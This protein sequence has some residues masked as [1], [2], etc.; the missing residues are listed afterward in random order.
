LFTLRA[1]LREETVV[2]E[3]RRQE[4]DGYELI[5]GFDGD[6][7]VSLAGVRPGHTLARGEHVFVDD[8]ITGEANR[9]R[10]HARALL[11]WIASRATDGGVPRVYLD[12]R[13]T[14]QGF[15]ADVG[16]HFLTSVP[17]WIESDLLSR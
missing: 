10:G 14:A 5:G 9:G 15:Y 7:L 8:L 3:I 11:Q 2:A 16:F 6:A 17:C 1:R 12:S 13:D 4:R